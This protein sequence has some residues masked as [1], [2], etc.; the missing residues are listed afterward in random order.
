MTDRMGVETVV[1][2]GGVVGAATAWALAREGREVVLLEAH[3]PAHAVGASHASTR[4]FNPSYAEPAYLR[5]LTR[6]LP[7]WRELEAESGETI[8]EQ[9]GIVNRGPV[10]DAERLREN[11]PRAGFAV[12]TVPAGEAAGRWPGMRFASDALFLPDGGRIWAERAVRAFHALAARFGGDIRHGVRV[13]GIRVL[14]DGTAEVRAGDLVVRARRAVV[15]AGAWSSE[16]L[17]GVVGLPRLRVTEE[18]PAHFALAA[19]DDGAGW[20]SFNHFAEPSGFGWLGPIYGLVSPGEGLKVGWHGAGPEVTPATRTFAPEEHVVAALRAYVREWMPG[21]D[22]DRLEPIS[23]TY[24][25]REGED[26]ILDAAGPIIVAAG[27]AGHGFKFAPALGEH[28][29]S[30]AT[31]AGHPDPFFALRR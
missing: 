29:A 10:P 21:A 2:G 8:L 9:T 13:D 22:P 5:L 31:G 26:F 15:A 19:G 30:L 3:E 20:P 27:F 12:E 7:L 16:L 23:C 24:T 1:V 25:S 18:H 6:A 4:N 14:G 17:A 28:L 11:A